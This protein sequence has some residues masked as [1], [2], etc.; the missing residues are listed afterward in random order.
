MALAELIYQLQENEKKIIRRKERLQRKLV[1]AK[2]A[3]T[4]NKI[5]ISE[6]LLPSYTNI[7]QSDKTAAYDRLTT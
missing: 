2:H 3:V 5:C 1:K 6:K 7:K 4:Y